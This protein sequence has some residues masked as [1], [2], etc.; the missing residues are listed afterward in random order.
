MVI[1]LLSFHQDME[2]ISSKEG[3]SLRLRYR[4]DDSENHQ[5][6]QEG[7]VRHME[8][9]SLRAK[10]N[11]VNRFG[12]LVEYQNRRESKEY[13]AGTSSNRDVRLHAWT[14]ETSYRPK[15]KIEIALKARVKIARDHYPDPITEASSF[16]V[17][18]RFG[19]AFRGKGHLRAELEFGEVRSKPSD[20]AL[21][22]EMLGG[23]QPGRTL[24]W[25]LLLTY[26]VTGH[27]MATLNYRGRQEPWR[28]GLYQTGQVEVRAFF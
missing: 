23:D 24:R 22:Y 3:F 10:G 27:V 11:P 13:L 12:L 2:Y 9:Q 26:R 7:L 1:G 17:L 6:V 25:T 4:K 20:R 15:Q 19:Y 14:L 16:F 8:E 5:I 28:K 18:P 21:P